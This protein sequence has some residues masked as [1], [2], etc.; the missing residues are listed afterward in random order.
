MYRIIAI[1]LA[2]A[3]TT[4]AS[5]QLWD[6]MPHGHDESL[7][8][9]QM[10]LVYPFDAQSA[11]D[12]KLMSAAKITGLEWIGGFWNGSPVSVPQWNI[13][14]YEDA[15]GKPPGGPTDPTGAAVAV[16][17]LSGDDVSWSDIGDFYYLYEAEL[18][19]AFFPT[20][21]ETYWIAVQPEFP[22]PPKWGFCRA[23]E[24]FKGNELMYGI[25]LL[26]VDYWEVSSPTSDLAFR[27]YGIECPADVTG[28][29]IVDVMDLLDVLSQWGGSGSADITSDG[30]VD[31]LDLLQVL[32]AW[33]PCA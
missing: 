4:C 13:I 30:I 23:L 15:G 33:G 25:P 10:D 27:L 28:D 3:V 8:V 22:F 6:N 2:S 1:G 24:S 20:P 5:A 14:F 32:A 16:Y 29:E 26:G 18:D 12:F 19:A 7:I 11:D 31:V 9:S 21:G 17:H